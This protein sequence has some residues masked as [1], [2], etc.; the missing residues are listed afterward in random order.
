MVAKRYTKEEFAA[1]PATRPADG[2]PWKYNVNGQWHVVEK[3]EAYDALIGD[4]PAPKAEVRV[5]LRSELDAI[6]ARLDALEAERPRKTK[7][8]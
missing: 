4:P 7:A 3:D 2:G 1:F 5:G 8:A 6:L